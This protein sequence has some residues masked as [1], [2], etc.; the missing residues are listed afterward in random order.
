MEF[1]STCLHPSGMLG[2]CTSELVRRHQ[3]QHMAF[4]MGNAIPCT[5]GNQLL[6]MN[7]T[8][9]HQVVNLHIRC[10]LPFN[11]IGRNNWNYLRL[12]TIR[13]M[14]TGK[15]G[16]KSS[17]ALD[18]DKNAVPWTVV[19][20]VPWPRTKTRLGSNF[21]G[22]SLSSGAGLAKCLIRCPQRFPRMN[23]SP[24]VSRE[25]LT[26]LKIWESSIL[27]RGRAISACASMM[28][29]G[30]GLGMPTW[31]LAMQGALLAVVCVRWSRRA[32]QVNPATSQAIQMFLIILW[33]GKTAE[34]SSTS[35]FCSMLE[36]TTLPSIISTIWKRWQPAPCGLLARCKALAVTPHRNSTVHAA[37]VRWLGLCRTPEVAV[38]TPMSLII[39]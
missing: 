31:C 2:Q 16:K 10:A 21:D 35:N 38:S 25:W 1:P 27:Q 18:W 37:W 29:T 15:R 4:W 26:E 33:R 22:K 6:G 23:I 36:G 17:P 20:L 32:M 5:L 12:K 34:Q 3:L 30:S 24:S 9:P 28:L 39:L 13:K 11:T 19:F 14:G 7:L 8:T